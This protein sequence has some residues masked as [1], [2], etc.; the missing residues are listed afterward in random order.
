[1]KKQELLKQINN[2]EITYNY[3]ETYNELYNAWVDYANE[4]Q[5]FDLEYV[6]EEYYGKDAIEDIVRNELETYGLER[7]Y[8][9]LGNADLT[10]D[11]FKINGYGNLE[12]IDISDLECIK[13]EL[14]SNLQD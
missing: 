6:F 9:F 1:M 8:Y 4:T 14:I 7:L 5:D 10:Q 3:E 11:V 2:I 12:S 13:D